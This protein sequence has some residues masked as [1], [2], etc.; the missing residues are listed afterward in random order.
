MFIPHLRK[1]GLMD[2][3]NA[4]SAKVIKAIEG[5]SAADLMR[6]EAGLGEQSITPV[7]VEDALTMYA[8]LCLTT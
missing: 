6:S 4:M 1:L 8:S 5:L 3:S 7:R 2:Y